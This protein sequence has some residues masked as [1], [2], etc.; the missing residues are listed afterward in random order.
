LDGSPFEH[1]AN[2]G[3]SLALHKVDYSN[4]SL[5]CKA[6]HTQDLHTYE[7]TSCIDCHTQH[8]TAFMSAHQQQYGSECLACHDGVDRLSNFEHANFFPLEGKHTTLA[9][10]SCHTNLVFRGTP[11]RCVDCHPEPDIHAGV[12]GLEC[13]DCHTAEAWS[14]ATLLQHKF[15][16]N[17]GVEAQGQQLKCD[18]CHSS[19]YIEYTC[20][21]CHE[22][23]QDE[24]TRKHQE[25]GI[26]AQELPECAKCHPDGKVQE[27]E[28]NR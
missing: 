12:F 11:D 6:C 1:L 8:D 21:N 2:T 7:R 5:G 28:G 16:L 15:P 24:I 23:Q 17:H 19:N 13:A 10:T 14:P 9:C 3:F 25:E 22:H 20:Y 26:S 4:Q 27:G 18:A